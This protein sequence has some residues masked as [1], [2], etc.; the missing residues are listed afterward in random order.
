MPPK[1]KEQTALAR[2]PWR[3]R[4]R[5]SWWWIKVI[6]KR[7]KKCQLEPWLGLP[8][9]APWS[10]TWKYKNTVSVQQL[11]LVWVAEANH[12]HSVPTVHDFHGKS[13]IS[14]WDL[15]VFHQLDRLN[16]LLDISSKTRATQ[17][18][19]KTPVVSLQWDERVESWHC[20]VHSMEIA[21]DST[22][23]LRLLGISRFIHGW[24]HTKVWNFSGPELCTSFSDST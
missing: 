5:G 10:L 11:K 24:V 7:V 15:A 17:I 4:R 19:F 9:T 2:A 6:K 1:T 22:T 23:S 18:V 12:E 20:P 8:S 21:F 13:I 3:S 16:R 14:T